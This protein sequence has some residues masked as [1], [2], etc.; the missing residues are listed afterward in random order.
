ML[1]G[2]VHL[3]NVL[4]WV[5][6]ILLLVALFQA[7][8][9]KNGL[10][11]TSLFLLISAHITLLLGLFQYFNSEMAGFKII[12]RV[13]G[14]GNVMKDS[15]ARFWVVEHISAMLLAIVLITLAR[16][17]VKKENFKGATLF[18]LIALLLVLA[19]VP[20]P[21]REGIARPWFPGMPL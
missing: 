19:A 7:L 4:R 20:W 11:K 16:G 18:Y 2:L 12:E 17:R 6:L 8:T 5:I 3:H 1:T 13:G 21:F 14:F 15:F 10:Q 9:K